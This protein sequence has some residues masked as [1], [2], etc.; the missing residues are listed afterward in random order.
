MFNV[1]LVIRTVFFALLL[2]FSL[3]LL[4]FAAW[5][6]SST[7]AIGYH[8]TGSSIFTIFTNSLL[9]ILLGC[10]VIEYFLPHIR[11]ANVL[12]ECGWAAIIAL[13]QLG[14]A[15]STTT[16]GS[17]LTC[18]ITG[19]WSICASSSVLIPVSWLHTFI[20]FAYFFM[21]SISAMSHFRA[22][23]DLWTRTIYTVDWFVDPRM[24]AFLHQATS[25]P[26]LVSWSEYLDGIKSTAGRKQLYGLE[27]DVE[28]APWA[29]NISV[30]RGKDDPYAASVVTRSGRSTP[31]STVP[32]SHRTAESV[33]GRS[34]I[35]LAYTSSSG[36]G[37]PAT[38]N[39][40][41]PPLPPRV[42]S[43]DSSLSSSGSRFLEGL[44]RD[45]RKSSQPVLP[46]IDTT[47]PFPSTIEDHD[48]P[49]PLPH[50]STW[51][52]ADGKF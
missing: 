12:V 14:A 4:V 15:I 22:Y 48:L 11:S 17:S 52:R 49:I 32:L 10:S 26:R 2:M 29:E 42:L 38:E 36:R 50:K 30:R 13:F 41:L 45:L 24:K 8:T 21:L 44:G 39:A 18:R 5:N 7:S 1:F 25:G 46:H 28:K 47:S 19:D 6:I 43:K 16:S 51:I 9:I 31:F 37:T 34:G 27:E 35:S 20:G 23:P 33:S 40:S 3:L